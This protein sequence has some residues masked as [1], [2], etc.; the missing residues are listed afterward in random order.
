MHTLGHGR[1]FR[2]QAEGVP[3]HGVQ[4]VETP[5]PFIAGNDVADGVVADMA[6]VNAPRGIGVHFKNIVLGP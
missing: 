4:Y 5:G 2:R 1:V 6:H 3:A